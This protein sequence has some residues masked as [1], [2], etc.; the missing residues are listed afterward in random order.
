MRL[1]DDDVALDRHTRGERR[2]GLCVQHEAY[3]RRGTRIVKT[4]PD[5]RDR[6]RQ[7]IASGESPPTDIREERAGH[8]MR[9]SGVAGP[10]IV[11]NGVSVDR[12]AQQIIPCR[13]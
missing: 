9:L 4:D 7:E 10:P 8:D 2:S 5:G 13:H 11:A 6:R 12:P 3:R 1:A